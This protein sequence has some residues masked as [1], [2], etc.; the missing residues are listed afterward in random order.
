MDRDITLRDLVIVIPGI[1]GSVLAKGNDELW[2]ISGTALT[3]YIKTKGKILNSLAFR[4]ELDDLEAELAYDNVKPVGVIEGVHGIPGLKLVGGYGSLIASLQAA[5]RTASNSMSPIQ[6]FSYDW[7]RDNRANA[8]RLE[9]FIERKLSTWREVTAHRSA[10]VII[11]AHS[12][13]GLVARYYINV[14]QGWTKCKTLFTIGTPHRGSPKSLGYLVNGY[15]MALSDL[16]DTLRTFPSIYQLLPIYPSV[17]TNGKYNRVAELQNIPNLN[18]DLVANALTFHREI[19]N[20][21]QL[22]SS[23]EEYRS[24]Y[25]IIP[26]VGTRQPTPQSA[27]FRDGSL[28]LSYHTPPLIDEFLGDGDG[29]VPRVSA[30]PIELSTEYRNTFRE[31]QHAFLHLDEIVVSDIIDRIKWMQGGDLKNVREPDISPEDASRIALSL[32]VDDLYYEQEVALKVNVINE[33]D[34]LIRL[35]EAEVERVE[36]G[37]VTRLKFIPY[38]DAWVLELPS[39]GE[40]LY[41]LTASSYLQYGPGPRVQGLFEVTKRQLA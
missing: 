18:Q 34:N 29:T 11:I 16:T 26:V 6:V 14:L 20:G 41:K 10:K 3:G 39:L 23:A 22:S 1:T 13:G 12:M 24:S 19:E 4:Q 25:R 30:V 35:I 40:G 21:V 28:N 38:A 27:T 8:R 7:R 9:R 5:F 33:G 17:S 36:D 32:L 2:N 37:S 31:E 15:K